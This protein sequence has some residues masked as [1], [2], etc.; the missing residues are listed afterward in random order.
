MRSKF[1]RVFN[2]SLFLMNLLGSLLGSLCLAEHTR[3][4]NPNCLSVE[5]FG[6]AMLYSFQFDR[7]LNDDLAAGVGF[8]NSPVEFPGGISANR[9]ATLIPIFASYYF[10]RD[11]GSPFVMMGASIVTNVSDVKS[12]QSNPGRITFSSSAALPTFGAGYENRSDTGFTFRISVYGLVAEQFK[13][14]FGPTL[15]YSF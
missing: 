10:I 4:T 9:N 12:L 2:M 13:F 14:W 8:G 6:K 5:V 15:G 7:M 1:S 11:Q 3:V